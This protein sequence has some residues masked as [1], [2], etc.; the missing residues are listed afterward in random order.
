MPK[1]LERLV[2]QPTFT[3]QPSLYKL[4]NE[5][6][7]LY[8]TIT[9]AYGIPILYFTIRWEILCVSKICLSPSLSLSVCANTYCM[10]SPGNLHNAL[11]LSKICT[12]QRIGMQRRFASH[13]HNFILC[14]AIIVSSYTYIFSLMF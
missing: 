9:P 8:I 5:K 2:L 11:G 3:L 6:L 13:L 1:V 7:A 12:V 4:E 10:E 14:L